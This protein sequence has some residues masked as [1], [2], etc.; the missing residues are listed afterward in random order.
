MSKHT[1]LVSH[2][3]EGATVDEVRQHFQEAYQDSDIIDVQ[4]GY[5]VSK[6]TKLDKKSV[7]YYFLKLFE[8]NDFDTELKQLKHERDTKLSWMSQERDQPQLLV[9]RN[10]VA[11]Q[12][13]TMLMPLITIARRQTVC[14]KNVKLSMK[15]L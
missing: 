5:D 15:Q 10:Y 4:M 6:L 3:S 2:I 1:L 12:M 9:A 11:V 8:L 13:P 7:P 14:V